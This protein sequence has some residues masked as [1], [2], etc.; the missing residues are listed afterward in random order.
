MNR[1]TNSSST[2]PSTSQSL[3]RRSSRSLPATLTALVLL[4]AA[5]ACAWIGITRIT[6]GTWPDFLRSGREATASLT[7][8]SPAVITAAILLAL[9]GLT[10][11]L[12]ALLPGQHSTIRLNEPDNRRAGTS[13]AVLTRRGLSKIAAAHIDRTDG[14]DRSSVTTTAKRMDVNVRTPLHDAG[15]LSN[16]LEAALTTKMHDLGVTPKPV[17]QV[18]VRTTND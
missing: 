10:L 12:A 7:W 6:T 1:P 14:V 2:S 11:L 9:L 16:R 8:N 4:A 3:H 15:D 18:R 17:I 13:E 5:V